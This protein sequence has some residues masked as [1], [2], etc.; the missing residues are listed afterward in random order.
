MD[1]GAGV[2]R[3]R[4]DRAYR[5][6]CGRRGMGDPGPRK[7]MCYVC[8]CTEKEACID[9]DG[10]SCRWANKE[11]TLCNMCKERYGR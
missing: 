6:E 11:R 3:L 1:T 4:A 7:G 2:M 9:G 5:G 10:E 8:G